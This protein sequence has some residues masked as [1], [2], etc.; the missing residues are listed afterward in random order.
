M[1]ENIIVALIGLVGTIITA[2]V[3]NIKIKKYK[4][5][6]A[7]YKEK[8]YVRFLEPNESFSAQI[9]EVKHICMYTVNSHELLNKVNTI[10]EQN[11]RITIRKL[12]ILVRKK[13]QETESDITILNTNISLWKSLKEKGKIKDIGNFDELKT[14]LTQRLEKYQNLIFTEDTVKEAKE[15][16]AGLNKFK[17]AIE[18]RRKEIKKL[19]LKPYD[20]FE[21]KVKELTKLIDEPINTINTQIQTFEEKRITQKIEEIKEIYNGIF[22]GYTDIIPLEKVFIEQWKNATFKLTKIRVELQAMFD[23]ILGELKTINEMN[24][25]EN[26]A[27]QVK[28]VYLRS[29]NFAQAIQ[30]KTRLEELQ[31]KLQKQEEVQKAD[32]A[33]QVPLDTPVK[34]EIPEIKI[35]E[36]K[37]WVKGT[38]EQLKALGQYM[39]ENNIEYGGF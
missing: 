8:S 32:N 29:F 25:P 6:A 3:G 35:Y 7:S 20:E 16:K 17:E 31:K 38:A 27:L 9:P 21:N 12:T 18:T 2:V 30:E 1:S 26:I 23:Q 11:P 39:K 4:H 14:E 19:C 33:V 15:T 5:E 37:F 10:M 34:E 22:E 24:L 36:R 28:D 13:A